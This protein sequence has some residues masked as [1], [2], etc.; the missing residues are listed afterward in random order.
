MCCWDVK[1]GVV[2]PAKV[3]LAS[4]MINL[5][6]IGPTCQFIYIK[7]LIS[8][9]D[10]VLHNLEYTCTSNDFKLRVNTML[11]HRLVLVLLDLTC[12]NVVILVVIC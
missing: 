9:A 8:V 7:H 11:R 10:K 12:F 4:L 1:I 5:D 3:L 6:S 2:T